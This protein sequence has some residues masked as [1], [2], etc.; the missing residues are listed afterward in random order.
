MSKYLD[1]GKRIFFQQRL[2]VRI[3]LTIQ[4]AISPGIIHLGTIIPNTQFTIQSTSSL[5]ASTVLYVIYEQC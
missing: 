4:N 3:L 1:A 2:S 5:D